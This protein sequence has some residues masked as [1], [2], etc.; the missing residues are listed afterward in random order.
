MSLQIFLLLLFC[1]CL[2]KL[3]ICFDLNYPKHALCIYCTYKK[4]GLSLHKSMSGTV[5]ESNP[6][7]SIPIVWT[8][9]RD[10]TDRV[11]PP[12]TF[13][14]VFPELFWLLALMLCMG[15]TIFKEEFGEEIGTP[16]TLE[17]SLTILYQ[18]DTM[19]TPG[20]WVW[21]FWTLFCQDW[22]RIF[23]QF[24]KDWWNSLLLCFL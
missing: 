19:L 17:I 16:P 20:N 6:S 12:L 9:W 24:S 21:E 10:F 18:R 8:F 2:S 11:C 15:D 5:T 3:D 1:V 13:G 22:W 23:Q 14:H 7:I 4:V